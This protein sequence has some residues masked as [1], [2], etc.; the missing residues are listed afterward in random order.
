M[1]QEL[2]SLAKYYKLWSKT[3]NYDAF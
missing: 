1:N 2:L 3:I